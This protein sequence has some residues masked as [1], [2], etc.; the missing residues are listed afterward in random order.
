MI[1][2]SKGRDDQSMT[3]GNDGGKQ[4]KPNAP[5]TLSGPPPTL[6]WGDLRRI[7]TSPVYGGGGPEGWRGR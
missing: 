1:V 5:S 7:L 6:R 3:I 2:S 4:S